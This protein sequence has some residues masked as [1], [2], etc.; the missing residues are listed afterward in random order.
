MII[1][2]VFQKDLTYSG[3][4]MILLFEKNRFYREK[5]KSE[6]YALKSLHRCEK[7]LHG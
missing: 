4:D 2:I 5:L 6:K 3:M 7:G 1:I